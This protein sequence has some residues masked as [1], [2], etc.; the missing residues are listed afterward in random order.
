MEKTGIFNK[1]SFQTLHCV[2][3]NDILTVLQKG[4]ILILFSQHFLLSTK[5]VFKNYRKI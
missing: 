1:I 4:Q 3:W 2:Y 5:K